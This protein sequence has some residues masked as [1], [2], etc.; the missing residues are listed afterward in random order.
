[1]LL[2]ALRARTRKSDDVRHKFV[3]RWVNRLQDIVHLQDE[4]AMLSF[5]VSFV[6]H[7]EGMTLQ[8]VLYDDP[9]RHLGER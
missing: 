9:P 2:Q 6:D 5:L 1:M 8:S 4:D 7:E 3:P